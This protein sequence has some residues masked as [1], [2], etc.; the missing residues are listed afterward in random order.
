VKL[1]DPKVLFESYMRSNVV[2]GQSL[3]KQSLP[4]W[5]SLTGR[6][7]RSGPGRARRQQL[8]DRFSAYA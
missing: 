4:Y 7:V 6:D 8:L 1:L 3:A 2:P 5:E